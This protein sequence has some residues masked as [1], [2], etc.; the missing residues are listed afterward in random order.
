MA[1][2][3]TRSAASP[4][5]FGV[6]AEAAKRLLS[7]MLLIRRFEEKAGQ[8]YGMGAIGGFC[9]LY[10][11]QEAIVVGMHEALPNSSNR[12]HAMDT[13]CAGRCSG[14]AVYDMLVKASSAKK[15]Y[16]FASHSHRFAANV[17]DQPFVRRAALVGVDAGQKSQVEAVETF[18]HHQHKRFTTV[19]E[20]LDWIVSEDEGATHAGGR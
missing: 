10:I 8:L 7:D 19:D 18:S 14:N 2:T 20:A 16:V 5:G 3:L 11:G 9:H 15:V 1:K 12:Y 13:T 17:Y 4:S 6:D